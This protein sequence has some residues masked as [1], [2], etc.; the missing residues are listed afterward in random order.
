MREPFGTTRKGQ[1]LLGLV[2]LVVGLGG[3]TGLFLLPSVF[4]PIVAA[5]FFALS[6]VSHAPFDYD[7]SRRTFFACLLIVLGLLWFGLFV[8]A[9]AR[10]PARNRSIDTYLR[11]RG[12]FDNSRRAT[13]A[14][15]DDPSGRA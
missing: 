15:Q 4:E 10:E 2:G 6:W 7:P 12:R 13:M 5:A 3:G 9:F 1:A 14:S 8:M 11:A